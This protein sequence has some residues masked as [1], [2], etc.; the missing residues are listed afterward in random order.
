[1]LVTGTLLTACTADQRQSVSPTPTETAGPG[2]NLDVGALV[3]PPAA[4]VMPRTWR[5]RFVIPYGTGE[6]LLGTSP[7]GEG[8]SMD[9]G[10]ESGAPGPDG[11]WWFLDAAK[12]RLAHYDANG[13]YLGQAKIP[14]NLLVNRTYFQWQLPHVLADG[15]LFAARQSEEGTH[16]LRMRDG[17]LD[18][19]AVDGSF[20]P[21]FDDGSRLYGFDDTSELVVV[22]PNDGSLS[23]T[24]VL[25]TASGASFSFGVTRRGLRIVLPGTGVSKVLPTTTASGSP[26]HVGIQVRAGADEV[27]H[28]FLTGAGEDDESVQLVGATLIDAAGHVADVEPLSNP[29]TPADPGSPAQ[30]AM[31]PGSSTPMLVYVDTDGVHVYERTVSSE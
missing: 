25:R 29:F 26:A 31:A 13:G 11:T 15:T 3:I 10:P 4:A 28:L 18:E 24:K 30:L 16:L 6:V 1:M 22:D 7:G 5:E 27:I 17:V 23:S 9:L 12:K 2:R 8:G 14:K 19:V 20:S 21:I